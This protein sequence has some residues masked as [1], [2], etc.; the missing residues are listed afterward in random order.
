M[1]SAH[2][3]HDAADS[4][5]PLLLDNH[6]QSLRGAATAELKHTNESEK[7]RAVVCFMRLFFVVAQ[8]ARDGKS[9]YKHAKTVA[10]RFQRL[11]LKV[12]ANSTRRRMVWFRSAWLGDDD[13]YASVERQN[14]FWNVAFFRRNGESTRRP[15]LEC[16]RAATRQ[17][18][19]AR[20][21]P[22]HHCC[23]PLDCDRAACARRCSHIRAKNATNAQ[24]RDR[25]DE[26]H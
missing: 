13:R 17:G 12:F 23:R 26:L 20:S 8:A 11:Q 24:R 9:S 2:D 21:S 15:H 18:A 16:C 22:Q 3:A 7:K 5:P 6:R 1:N 19:G 10:A 25:A 14:F 4:Q